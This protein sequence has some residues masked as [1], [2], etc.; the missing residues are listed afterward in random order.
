M[1]Y[2]RAGHVVFPIGEQYRESTAGTG[3]SSTRPPAPLRPASLRVTHRTLRQPQIPLD[4]TVRGDGAGSPPRPSAMHADDPLDGISRHARILAEA[5]RSLALS[6]S[7]AAIYADIARIART[8]LGADGCTIYLA[9][10]IGETVTRVYETGVGAGCGSRATEQFWDNAAGAA[11]RSG[12]A[13]FRGDLRARADVPVVRCLLGHGVRSL[14]L[15]PLH[16]EGRPRGLL[17]LRY[18]REQS[19]PA[20]DRTLL[21]DFGAHVALALRNAQQTQALERRAARLA[22]V[23]EVQQ[24]ISAAVSAPEMYA[25]IY[26]AVSSVLDAPCFTLLCFDHDRELFVP[27]YVVD[28]RRPVPCD[29]L[30]RLPLSDGA[31]SQAF[32]TGVP[33]VAARSRLGWTGRVHEVRGDARIAVVLTAPIIDAERTLGVMQVQ[34]YDA[35]A[36]DWDD[37][38][39]VMLVARQAGTA[40][41]RMRAFETEHRTRTEAESA[42]AR[43]RTLAAALEAL[44][45]P[46]FICSTNASIVH[47]NGAALREYGYALAEFVGMDARRLIVS[48][49]GRDPLMLASASMRDRG[50]WSGEMLQHRR[51]GAEFPAWVTISAIRNDAGDQVG[52]VVIVRDLTEE[53]RVAEQ[54]RQSEK[55]IALGE[56]V[57]GVAHEVNNPLAGISAF[58]QLLQEDSL[59]PEQREAAQI[60]KRE[61]DRAVSV[62]RD[63]L[64]FARKTGPRIVAIDVNSLIEQTLRLRGYGLRTEGIDVELRLASDLPRVRGDD[65]QLQQV[66]LNLIVN[67]EHAMTAV[68]RRVLTLRTALEGRRVVIEVSDTGTGMP[69]DVQKRIFEPFFTTKTDG[70]GT[71]L[72]L[73]VSYGIIQTHRGT[74][75]VQSA[76]GAGAAFRI[77]LPTTADAA[78]ESA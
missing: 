12:E 46:V 16:V 53:R 76:P 49:G 54:L 41:A 11:V 39:I 15:L 50:G 9:D 56:L 70:R 72:G 5:A 6:A 29:E 38:D 73:S 40:M 4:P 26:H 69:A 1:R 13:V 28:D 51:Q 58:A 14:A 33:N 32:R 21:Q 30:P 68:A 43:E 67:A 57:A 17:V 7:P 3:A 71:G 37:L 66:L 44:D 59:T 27:T 10:P 20:G 62:V 25:A 52:A 75:T 78:V 8:A 31:T 47:A 34:S 45:Q 60:I 2:S 65:R 24:A 74:L 42:L 63:L 55:L 48:A 18:A 61:A 22:A 19:F 23:A 36:Y 35:D 64:T 77:A